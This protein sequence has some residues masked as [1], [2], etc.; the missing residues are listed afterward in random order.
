MKTRGINLMLFAFLLSI[1]VS[2]KD[3]EKDPEQAAAQTENEA[4]GKVT[5]DKIKVNPAHGLPGH[6]C[7]LPVGAPLDAATTSNPTPTSELPSTSVSPIRIDQTP[8]V[9]PP[10]GEPYHDCSIPVGAKLEKS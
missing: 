2:C 6:R 8:D 1:V 10:H 3:Q 5:E 9:N 7:D 4:P